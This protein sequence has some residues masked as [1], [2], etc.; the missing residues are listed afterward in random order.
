MIIPK[1]CPYCGRGNITKVKEPFLD[2]QYNC[3]VCNRGWIVLDDKYWLACFDAGGHIYEITM[4]NGRI[5]IIDHNGFRD[6]KLRKE[7]W[8]RVRNKN[9]N[10]N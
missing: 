8:D 10:K 3:D 5:E 4:K 6:E 2:W 9:V 7:L 1:K